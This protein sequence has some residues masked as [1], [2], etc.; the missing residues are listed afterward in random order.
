VYPSSSAINGNR[1]PTT[2]LND[3]S[4]ETASK[5]AAISTRKSYTQRTIRTLI[6]L[7]APSATLSQTSQ[8]IRPNRKRLGKKAPRKAL[9][10][11]LSDT[12]Q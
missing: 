8:Y 4:R 1:S 9:L 3:N 5:M 2:S 10:S 6:I 7:S 12:L 11:K